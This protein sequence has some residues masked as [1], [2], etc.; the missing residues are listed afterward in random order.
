MDITQSNL[1]ALFIGFSKQFADAFMGVPQPILEAVGVK[2][3]SKTR[4]QRYPFVQAIAG[5]MR[6]W[7]GERQIQNIVADGFVVTNAK[8]ENT[9]AIEREDVED[10]QFAVYTEMLIPELARHAKLLPEQQLAGIFN[11]NPTCFDGKNLFNQNHYINPQKLSGAQSNDL[12]TGLPLNGTNL[13][14][15]QAALMSLVGADSIKLGS[16]GQTLFVPPSLKYTAE[17]LATG[18]LIAENKNGVTGVF[19]A[20]SNV[21]QSQFKVVTSEWLTDTGDPT[22]AAWFLLDCRS[23]IRAALWQERIAPQLVQ[24]V[25]PANP[26]VFFQDQFFMGGRARGA[27]APGIWFKGI[28]VN[29]TPA[30]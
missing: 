28:R 14:K 29:A 8:W 4:D 17:L 1:S 3:P 11:T 12:G 26:A 27:A 5:A 13:A 23:K 7:T 22:T 6:Q 19:G 30:T 24:M 25:D 15:A 18:S 20:Q 10:D 16:Y 21:F 2:I 9:L